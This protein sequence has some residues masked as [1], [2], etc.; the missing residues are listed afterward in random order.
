[1]RRLFHA[2][3]ND[4]KQAEAAFDDKTMVPANLVCFEQVFLF[5]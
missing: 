4:E 3:V 2:F 1:M 5:L